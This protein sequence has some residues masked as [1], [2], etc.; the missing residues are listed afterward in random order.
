[1]PLLDPET[2]EDAIVDRLKK[3]TPARFVGAIGAE[4]EAADAASPLPAVFVAYASESFDS[5]RGVGFHSQIG[6]ATVTVIIVAEGARSARGGRRGVTG[7]HRI[8]RT[9]IAALTGWDA[10]TDAISPLRYTGMDL[11]PDNDANAERVQYRYGFA[12]D[13]EFSTTTE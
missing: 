12:L 11:A 10:S 2:I 3:K 4:D 1:M 7:A 6:T 8:G 9:V 5:P 13:F